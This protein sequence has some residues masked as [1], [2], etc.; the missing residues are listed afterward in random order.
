MNHLVSEEEDPFHHL[1]KGLFAP[2]WKLYRFLI[3]KFLRFKILTLGC[4]LLLFVVALAILVLSATGIMP[5][6]KVKFFPGNYF[7]YHVTVALP[8]GTAIE[9]TDS[10][11]RDISRFIISLGPKQ[12]Q[13]A[14]GS[15]GFYEDEESI[16]LDSK[17]QAYASDEF[18]SYGIK[19]NFTA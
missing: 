10:V 9:K 2:L 6:I 4:V 17:I 15:A 13:S 16:G 18:T 11:V 7:R 19:E 8:A 1:R 14:S 3:G 5:L 12:A